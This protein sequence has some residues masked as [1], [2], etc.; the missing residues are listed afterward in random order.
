VTFYFM[1]GEL[2]SFIP[3]NSEG[4]ESTLATSFNASF[5]RC[6]V[7]CARSTQYVATPTLALPDTFYIHLDAFRAGVGSSEGS[8]IAFYA[9]ATEVFRLKASSATLQMSALIGAS[10]TNIG[11]A[12]AWAGTA[13]YETIDLYIDGNDASG[14]AKLYL[15]GTLVGTASAVDLSLV[16]SITSARFY[17]YSSTQQYISQVI[18]ADEPTIGMRLLTRYPN[19]AGSDTAWTGDYTGIDEIIINDADFINSSTNGQVEMVTQTGPA[20]TGYT[21]RAVG[22]YARSKWGGTG[23]ENLQLALRSGGTNY[24]S[25]SKAQDVGYSAYGNIW[26]TNPATTADWL[27]SQIDALQPGAKA[28]T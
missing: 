3:S 14:E 4:I 27:S 12:V 9:G 28:V 2:A 17:G 25:T 7:T 1:G 23:P 19:G 21:P 5:A 15:G 26:E 18:I 24:F 6:S 20:I 13:G 16:A 10:I 8:L 22:V 11:S